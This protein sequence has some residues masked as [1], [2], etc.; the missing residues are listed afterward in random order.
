M[1]GTAL[2]LTAND[3]SGQPWDFS[4]PAQR[5][6]AE[7]MT[8]QVLGAAQRFI[9]SAGREGGALELMDKVLF[10]GQQVQSSAISSLSTSSS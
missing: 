2:D 3:E 10:P 6:K 9:G 5:R 7:D 8:G 1:P 4:V